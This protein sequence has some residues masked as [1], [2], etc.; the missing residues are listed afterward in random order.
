M[1]LSAAK[2]TPSLW[3]DVKR[4]WQGWSRLERFAV[5]TVC[6]GTVVSAVLFVLAF[7]F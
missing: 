5:G 1:Q 7:S 6:F 2:Q 4:D 3:R